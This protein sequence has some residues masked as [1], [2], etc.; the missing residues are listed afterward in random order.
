MT[1]FGERQA[2]GQAAQDALKVVLQNL[3]FTVIGVGQE[4]WLPKSVHDAL[5]QNHD[6]LM[7][8]SVRYQPDLLAFHPGFPAAYWEVKRNT[9]PGTPN[10]AIE[11]A[12][13]QE[14]LAR[15]AKGERII[16]AFLEVDNTWHAQWSNWLRVQ[17]DK[18]AVRQ[19][20]K[21]SHTPYLLI[22][23]TSASPLLGFLKTYGKPG[24]WPTI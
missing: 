4:N 8:R 18:S 6:D 23:K 9:T 7:I 14:A 3:G 19:Q 1:T 16:F 5:R 22:A 21:G 2:A 17:G 12:C 13:Y 20:S 15:T 10:F 24:T 11:V